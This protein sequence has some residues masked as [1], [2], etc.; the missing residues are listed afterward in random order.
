MEG[1]PTVSTSSDVVV[2]LAALEGGSERGGN[3]N[4]GE[5]DDSVELH[6]EDWSV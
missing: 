5:E 4:E 2:L 3:A 6:C 1:V